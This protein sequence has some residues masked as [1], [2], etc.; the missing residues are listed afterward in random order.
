VARPVKG[1]WYK[2]R[3]PAVSHGD[4]QCVRK[5]RAIEHSHLLQVQRLTP[6]VDNVT[7]SRFQVSIV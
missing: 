1:F 5:T 4:A 3:R 2:S 7:K 6:L